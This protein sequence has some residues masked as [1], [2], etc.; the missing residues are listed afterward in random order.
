VDDFHLVQIIG[1]ATVLNFYYPL[2]LQV[3]FVVG[4]V[5]NLVE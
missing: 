5:G 1:L 3:Q 2:N 4:S